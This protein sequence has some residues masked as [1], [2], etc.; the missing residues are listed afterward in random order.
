MIHRTRRMDEDEFGRD[1]KNPFDIVDLAVGSGVGAAKGSADF[2]DDPFENPFAGMVGD[3]YDLD[4]PEVGD[5]YFVD[6]VEESDPGLRDATSLAPA[7]SRETMEANALIAANTSVASITAAEFGSVAE[8]ATPPGSGSGGSQRPLRTSPSKANEATAKDS[9]VSNCANPFGDEETIENEIGSSPTT[10]DQPH[11]QHKQPATHAVPER[12][13]SNPFGDE[14]NDEELGTDDAGLDDS[15]P[16]GAYSDEEGE[17]G[18]GNVGNKDEKRVGQS[19][20][21]GNENTVQNLAAGSGVRKSASVPG[22]N[23]D[24]E[25]AEEEGLNAGYINS[26]MELDENVDAVETVEEGLDELDRMEQAAAASAANSSPRSPSNADVADE[27]SLAELD[28]MEALAAASS[29]LHDAAN[30]GNPF[31]NEE[32]VETQD[33]EINTAESTGEDDDDDVDIQV[34]DDEDGTAEADSSTQEE[35]EAA[36]VRSDTSPKIEQPARDHRRDGGRFKVPLSGVGLAALGTEDVTNNGGAVAPRAQ[37]STGQVTPHSV[38]VDTFSTLASARQTYRA[39]YVLCFWS[40]GATTCACDFSTPFAHHL[41]FE[42][43]ADGRYPYSARQADDLSF[44]VG[45]EFEAVPSVVQDE[46][47]LPVVEFGFVCRVH[48]SSKCSIRP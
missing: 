26:D 34:A 43:F 38:L 2:E 41:S 17:A 16:F 10:Q 29:P 25:L 15:N 1:K 11:Q 35:E 23:S 24:L 13:N 22:Y 44:R 39:L 31:D 7:V 18:T 27:S 6:G 37:E 33:A 20:L 14:G 42:I 4:I 47:G 45:D 48:E 12:G 8:S 46:S 9:G 40:G 19:Q 36:C 5:D 32:A 30:E 3:A 28:R 21:R